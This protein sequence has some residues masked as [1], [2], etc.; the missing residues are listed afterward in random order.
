MNMIL[1][2]KGSTELNL[3][4]KSTIKQ[5]CVNLIIDKG[6]FSHNKTSNSLMIENISTNQNYPYLNCNTR[7]VLTRATIL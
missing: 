3:I 2:N 7:T 4:I 1:N 6:Q 5:K